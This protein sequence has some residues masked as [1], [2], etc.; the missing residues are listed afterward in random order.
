MVLSLLLLGA[1]IMNLWIN[2]CE[3]HRTVLGMAVTIGDVVND[4][5]ETGIGNKIPR[6][7]FGFLY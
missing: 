5:A 2:A 6:W 3:R 4:G 7:L 1:V